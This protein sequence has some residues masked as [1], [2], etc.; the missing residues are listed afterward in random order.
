MTVLAD[1]SCLLRLPF[2]SDPRHAV[3]QK[4]IGA[5]DSRG[6]EVIIVQQNCTEFRSA[7]GRPAAVNGLGLTPQKADDESDKIEALFRLLSDPPGVCAVWRDLCKR[8][9][10]SGK[11]VHDTRLVAA[12]V[13]A[14][15][16]TVLTWNPADFRRFVPLVPELTVLTPDDL[17][18]P[19]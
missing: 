3:T 4:A 8:A 18:P 5:L 14:G 11:Q 6:Q 9:G 10:V 7:A 12:C 13:A 1:T 17:A 16:E 19:A 2:E 15:V